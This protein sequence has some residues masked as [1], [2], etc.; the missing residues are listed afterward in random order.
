MMRQ[1]EV[2]VTMTTTVIYEGE[3]SH[4]PLV[5][6]GSLVNFFLL[7]LFLGIWPTMTI[8]LENDIYC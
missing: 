1:M 8:G 3:G 4:A 7:T 5:E 2:M 6:C